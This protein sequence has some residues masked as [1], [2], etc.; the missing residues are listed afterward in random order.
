[1]LIVLLGWALFLRRRGFGLSHS[2]LPS[3]V[4][5]WMFFY[6]SFGSV[7]LFKAGPSQAVCEEVLGWLAKSG[8]DLESDVQVLTPR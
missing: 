1:M 2:W 7:T 5:V 6:F 3:L 8:Y 4:A